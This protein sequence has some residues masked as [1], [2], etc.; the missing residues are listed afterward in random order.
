MRALILGLITLLSSLSLY[1][2]DDIRVL[3]RLRTSGTEISLDRGDGTTVPSQLGSA[4]LKETL[5]KLKP[6]DE[7]LIVGHV[8]NV[9]S[10]VEGQK[11]SR[12]IFIIT[13]IHPVSLKELG[14]KDLKVDDK[15]V[16]FAAPEPK[17]QSPTFKANNEVV[18]AIMLTASI[19]MIMNLKTSSTTPKMQQ[20]ANGLLLFSAG[21][22]ASGS[23]VYDQLVKSKKMAD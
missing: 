9:I 8:S 13:G 22:M 17:P 14:I 15:L 1:A 7:A 3:A 4:K 16:H 10:T 23:F 5:E 6:S 20:D 2:Q 21:A 12:P 19:L 11:S 18:G